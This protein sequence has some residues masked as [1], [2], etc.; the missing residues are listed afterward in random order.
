MNHPLSLTWETYT[1]SWK[2]STLAEKQAWFAQSRDPH[3]VFAA[4][5][6]HEQTTYMD[7]FQQQVLS[8]SFQTKAF[9]A[10]ALT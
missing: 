6:W 5:G 4:R 2:A 9:W 3:C 8:D 1:A 7:T 10:A